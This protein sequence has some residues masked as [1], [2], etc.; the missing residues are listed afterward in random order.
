[1]TREESLIRNICAFYMQTIDTKKT[2]AKFSKEMHDMISPVK[3]IEIEKKKTIKVFDRKK[4]AEKLNTIIDVVCEVCE[5]S[6][7]DFV[8]VSKKDCLV[9]ARMHCYYY[10]RNYTKLSQTT[11]GAFCGGRDHTTV[12]W[13][14]NKRKNIF[15]CL[16][17]KLFE[18]SKLELLIKE[19]DA[20]IKKR[21][22]ALL[23]N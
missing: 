11:I 15:L 18:L 6:K 20:E 12:I 22:T 1:M 10:A 23:N 14:L 4:E 8:S 19:Q 2:V 5:V 17:S 13:S 9:V 21:L 7:H 16:D 3:V